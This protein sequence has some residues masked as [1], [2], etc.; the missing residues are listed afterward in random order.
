MLSVFITRCRR[1]R[2]ERRALEN[3]TTDIAR[4]ARRP[5]TELPPGARTI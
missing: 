4:H 1:S 3:L 5:L 2:R